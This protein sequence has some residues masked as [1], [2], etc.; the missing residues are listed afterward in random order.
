M[1]E[2]YSGPWLSVKG[3]CAHAG[4]SRGAIYAAVNKR[5]LRHTRVGGRRVLR[6][7]TSWIDEWLDKDQVT[8]REAPHA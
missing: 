4:V 7:Q 1:D 6:F 5:E 3:A 2:L 8:P